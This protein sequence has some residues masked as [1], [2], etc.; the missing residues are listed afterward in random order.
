M[1]LDHHGI[2]LAAGSVGA[3]CLAVWSY[4]NRRC[5][6]CWRLMEKCERHVYARLFLGDPRHKCRR[7]G[8]SRVER[9]PS[10]FGAWLGAAV[11]LSMWAFARAIGAG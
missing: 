4:F 7:C 5:P 3:L 1:S 8:T 10:S 9:F 2:A 11:V 6:R